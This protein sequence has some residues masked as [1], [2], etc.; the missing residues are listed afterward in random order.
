M[1][2]AL[3]AMNQ[4]LI[5]MN[6]AD[7]DSVAEMEFMDKLP[8]FVNKGLKNTINEDNLTTWFD[9]SIEIQ[10]LTP[11]SFEDFSRNMGFANHSVLTKEDLS[12]MMKI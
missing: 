2:I 5:T 3:I 7:M 11:K 4:A 1:S 8:V 10:K 9:L 6:S 12:G